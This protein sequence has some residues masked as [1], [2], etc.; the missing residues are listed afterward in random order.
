MDD[1]NKII[2]PIER[3]R[4]IAEEFGVSR[5]AMDA[6][7][8]GPL[9][10][11][12]LIVGIFPTDGG[13]PL[14]LP[15]ARE[16]LSNEKVDWILAQRS[17]EV[18]DADGRTFVSWVWEPFDPIANCER[19]GRPLRPG[20]ADR[21]A[22]VGVTPRFGRFASHCVEHAPTI[23]AP[24]LAARIL[25]PDYMGLAHAQDSSGRDIR[26]EFANGG[27]TWKLQCAVCGNP[28]APEPDDED[29]IDD[30]DADGGD[31]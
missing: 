3:M 12:E 24:E 22:P 19:C 1:D 21:G 9:M 14:C 18:T 29:D 7:N 13:D 2:N 4:R 15:C 11:Y 27:E 10:D 20:D 31:V 16:T 5:A 8:T 6:Y 30:E 23:L 17:H 26:I 25:A 28:L